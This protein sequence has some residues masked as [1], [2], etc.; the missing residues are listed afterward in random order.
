[1]FTILILCSEG[2]GLF[3]RSLSVPGV[4]DIES[5]HLRTTWKWFCFVLFPGLGRRY[6]R[7]SSFR[8]VNWILVFPSLSVPS[9]DGSSASNFHFFLLLVTVLF[10]LWEKSSY[11]SFRPEASL[12]LCFRLEWGW[13]WGDRKIAIGIQK[14]RW[15][16]MEIC[17]L[18][19]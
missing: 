13:G 7:F 3:D 2:P 9:W 18:T 1:M 8:F 17:R 6:R 12:S 19:F 10:S 16:D 4:W 5:A 14:F 15:E 11:S